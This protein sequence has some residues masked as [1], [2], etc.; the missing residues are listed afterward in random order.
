MTFEEFEA[1]ES[2]QREWIRGSVSAASGLTPSDRRRP[3]TLDP[4]HNVDGEAGGHA[5]GRGSDAWNSKEGSS[6]KEEEDRGG[7]DVSYFPDHL[8]KDDT[9]LERSKSAMTENSKLQKGQWSSLR[10]GFGFVMGDVTKVEMTKVVCAGTVAGFGIA[11]MRE[12]LSSFSPF[13]SS[14]DLIFG[15]RSRLSDYI[16]QRSI[17]S[18]PYISYS[19]FLIVLSVV[20]ACVSV[21]AGLWTM[22][23]ILKPKLQHS[24]LKKFGVACVLGSGTVSFFRSCFAFVDSLVDLSFF[25]LLSSPVAH[26]L[27][28]D[29]G[30]DLHGG[31]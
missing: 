31:Y 23:L 10:R 12:S 28:G 25:A 14:S 19:P 11:G 21:I 1:T 7:R 5:M 24:W 27:H 2:G 8:G 22:F 16:G 6:G 15:F 17:T 4:E 18:I 29:A 9:P 30:N 20:L 13:S 3:S 26:A